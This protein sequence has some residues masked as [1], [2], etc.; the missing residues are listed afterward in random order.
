M[1]AGNVGKKVVYH[2]FSHDFGADGHLQTVPEAECPP[3][4]EKLSIKK[5]ATQVWMAFSSFFFVLLYFISSA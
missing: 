3:A 2:N 5:L 4:K 1:I